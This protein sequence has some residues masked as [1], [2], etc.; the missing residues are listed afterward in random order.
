[1]HRGFGGE[2]DLGCASVGA[3][4]KVRAEDVAVGGAFGDEADEVAGQAD[5]ET[6]QVKS[7]ADTREIGFVEDN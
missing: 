7:V 4:A 1:V 6:R 2:G 3:Q 5:E